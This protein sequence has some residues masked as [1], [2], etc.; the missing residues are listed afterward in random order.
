[1]NDAEIRTWL[2][3]P[4]GSRIRDMDWWQRVLGGMRDVPPPDGTARRQVDALAAYLAC[5]PP[6]PK[7]RKR[8]REEEEW[9]SS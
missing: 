5:A 3:L 4:P 1:M 9:W 8:D 2:G 6:L 7:Y